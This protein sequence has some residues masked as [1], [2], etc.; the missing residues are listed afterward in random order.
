MM[1]SVANR[2]FALV[3]IVFFFIDFGSRLSVGTEETGAAATST[4]L[5][6]HSKVDFTFSGLTLSEVEE[7]FAWA[8]KDKPYVKPKLTETANVEP[9][10][11]VNT[12]VAKPAEDPIEILK[13]SIQNDGSK[14]INL[15]Q[16]LV[17]KGIFYESGYF[18]VI[19]VTNLSTQAVSYH[20]VS[21]GETFGS[22]TAKSIDKY[23]ISLNANEQPVILSLFESDKG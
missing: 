8:R 1:S 11:V 4:V 5:E 22:F 7:A 14:S 13:N 10:P 2:G 6:Q 3:L 12:P 21:V 23:K 9:P 16:L 15:G 18:A 19:E 17:L 20:K